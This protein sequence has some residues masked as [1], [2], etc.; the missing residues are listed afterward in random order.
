MFYVVWSGRQPDST[1]LLPLS[2]DTLLLVTLCT[3]VIF[4][5][6]ALKNYSFRYYLLLPWYHDGLYTCLQTCSTNQA[7]RYYTGRLKRT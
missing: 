1:L 2:T 5:H 7:D 3:A 4:F 6:A